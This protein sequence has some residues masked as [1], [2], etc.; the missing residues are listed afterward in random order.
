M[1]LFYIFVL[2]GELSEELSKNV[3]LYYHIGHLFGHSGEELMLLLLYSHFNYKLSF[4]AI[5]MA[6]YLSIFIFSTVFN[7]TASAYVD[8][9]NGFILFPSFK[10]FKSPPNFVARTFFACTKTFEYS[11]GE[12]LYNYKQRQTVVVTGRFNTRCSGKVHRI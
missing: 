11:Q 10:S 4:Y 6:E 3:S 8:I 7:S 12:D 9:G 2:S 1:Q 5:L